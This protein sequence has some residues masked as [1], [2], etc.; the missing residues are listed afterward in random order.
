MKRWKYVDEGVK[1]TLYRY[2]EKKKSRRILRHAG[3]SSGMQRCGWLVQSIKHEPL[4][5]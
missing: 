3:H 2:R 4:F 5:R 1:I